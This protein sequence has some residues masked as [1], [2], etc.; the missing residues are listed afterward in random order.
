VAPRTGTAFT[1]FAR[2]HGDYG[3]GGAAISVTLDADGRVER[4]AIALLAAGPVPVRAGEAEAVLA[5]RVPDA[6]AAREAAAAATAG[7]EPTGDMHGS[8][9]Y[10][11]ELIGT[12]V[13]RGIVQAA[14]EAA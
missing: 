9:R 6:A 8:A 7:I 3:L 1:E 2:R 10:R 4:A 12:L 5:G 11:R 13:E 14:K